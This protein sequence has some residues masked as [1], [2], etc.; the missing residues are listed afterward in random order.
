MSGT[1]KAY[2]EG[3]WRA[4][5]GA[6]RPRTLPAAVAPV[7]AGSALAWRDGDF[8]AAAACLCLAFALLI[9]IGT[10]FSNDYH[11]FV[12]GADTAARVGPRRAVAAGLVSPGAMRRASVLVMAAAFL[13]GLGLLGRGG[14][15]LL[16]VGAVSILCGLAYTGGPYPLGYHGL[17]DAS[18]LSSSVW[19]RFAQPILSRQEG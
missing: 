4:W 16:A 2:T 1:A 11:D 3:A 14:P 13:V 8:D 18:S 12:K 17:G 15:W 19:S 6:M 10:N 7:V 9:Q 5:V